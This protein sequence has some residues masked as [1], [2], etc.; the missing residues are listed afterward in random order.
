[1]AAGTRVL[2]RLLI[3]LTAT[4]GKQTFGFFNK[5][6]VM[7]YGF[8]QAVV[9]KVNVDFDVFRISTAVSEGG[10]TIEAGYV[11]TFR[12]RETRQERLETVDEDID[13]AEAELD[14]KVVSKDHVP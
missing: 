8:P 1:M 10:S 3:G 12:D 9:D 14:R 2:R 6:L 11:T 5:N 4:P 13:Y 7:E